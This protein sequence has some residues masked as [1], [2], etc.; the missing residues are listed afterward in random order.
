[1]RWAGLATMALA[2]WIS[3]CTSHHVTVDPIEVKP[4]QITVDVNLK[5]DREL[6]EFFDFEDEAAKPAEGGRS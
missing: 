4:I 3:G 6:D 2:A 1:M 5:V